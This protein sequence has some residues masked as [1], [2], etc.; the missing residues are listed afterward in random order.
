MEQV[1]LQGEVI[2]CDMAAERKVVVVDFVAWARGRGP[3]KAVIC[4][5]MAEDCGT[6]QVRLGERPKG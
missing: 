4:V 2:G 1:A 5:K 6:A 3:V